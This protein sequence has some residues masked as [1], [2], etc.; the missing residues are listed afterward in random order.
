[1]ELVT[2]GIG[3]AFENAL[4]KEV[5]ETRIRLRRRKQLPGARKEQR[6]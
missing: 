5:E 6:R 3:T 4:L 2:F 1:M